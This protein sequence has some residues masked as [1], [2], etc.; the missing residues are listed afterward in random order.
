MFRSLDL[1]SKNFSLRL[2]NGEESHRTKAGACCLVF[3]LFFT[4]VYG[5]MKLRELILRDDVD[6]LQ[7]VQD[8]AFSRFDNFT[9]NNGFDFAFGFSS[10]GGAPN[11]ELDP[12]N[13]ELVVQAQSWHLKE[14]MIGSYASSEEL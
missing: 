1:F 13:G 10:F 14:N 3:V 5:L 9:Y 4:V 2:D 7:T 12:S 11:W 6:V 8:K